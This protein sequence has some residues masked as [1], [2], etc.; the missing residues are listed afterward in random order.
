VDVIVDSSGWIDFLSGR[1][2][3]AVQDA[4]ATGRVVL[5]PLVVAELL[6]GNLAPY[7]RAAVGELLQD[8]PLHE[9]PLLH[10]M[11][12]GE[13]RRSLATHGVNVT[14]PDAHVA[15][16][17]I[18]RRAMLYSGDEIFTRIARHTPLRIAQLR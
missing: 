7:Q 3:A 10:W 15:Q 12:V 8:F 11:N 2:A 16:C 14:I 13:L 5:P 6:S 18:D 17:A 4:I 1:P 9:T